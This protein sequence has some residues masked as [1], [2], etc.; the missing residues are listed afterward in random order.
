VGVRGGGGVGERGVLIPLY[1]SRIMDRIL[2]TTFFLY[3]E[4]L[5]HA[6]SLTLHREEENKAKAS[7]TIKTTL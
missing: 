5:L 1:S 6:V 7:V 2:Q 4:Y 3:L